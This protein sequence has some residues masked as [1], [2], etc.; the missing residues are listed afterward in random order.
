MALTNDIKYKLTQLN[1]LDIIIAFNVL[2]YVLGL[3]LNLNW[4]E[5]P[6]NLNNFIMKPW[7]LI[8]YAFLHYDFLHILFNMLWLYFIG[9]MFLSLFNIKRALNVYFLGAMSGGFVFMLC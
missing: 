8:T 2:V 1:G 9:C 5:L 3:F 6:S 7:A 4:F